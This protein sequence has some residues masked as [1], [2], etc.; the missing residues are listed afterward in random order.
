MFPR[1]E[2]QNEGTFGVFP[3]NEKWNEGTF[4][5]S[6]GTKTRTRARSPKPPC[7]KPPFSLP[8]IK[9]RPTGLH[10]LQECLEI[11]DA[12][13]IGDARRGRKRNLTHE[14]PHNMG[15]E[16]IYHHRGTPLFSVC[17][18]TPRS[19]RKTKK[20]TVYPI[21]LGKQGKRV[22][23][24]GPERRVYTIEPQ[25]RKKNKKG[26]LHGGGVY[27]FFPTPHFM[28]RYT[29]FLAFSAQF[30]G[31]KCPYLTANKLWL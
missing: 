31:K 20:A 16:S 10:I 1:N 17:R 29:P 19:Q 23:T 7:T 6:P 8:V 15:K 2:N 24:I 14:W 3:W 13:L 5:C 18:P 22:Y 12:E 4:A 9:V 28:G 25:T 11:E 26:G 27:F 21:F 30:Y